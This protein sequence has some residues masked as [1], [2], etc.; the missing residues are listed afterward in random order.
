MTG[1]GWRGMDIRLELWG[2][3]DNE[4]RFLYGADDQ[5]QSTAAHVTLALQHANASL[6]QDP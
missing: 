5:I 4:A 2:T 6:A 1:D 3:Q